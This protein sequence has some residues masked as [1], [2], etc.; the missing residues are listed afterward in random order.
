MSDSIQ[1]ERRQYPRVKVSVPVEVLVEAS[2]SPMRCS[3]SDLSL[4]GCYIETIF[5]LPIGT[6]LDLQ[7]S[8]DTT[9]LIAATVV[10]CDPQVGNG[11]K[12]TKMLPEDREALKAYLEAAQQDQGLGTKGASAG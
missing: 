7:L 8:L 11:M 12:F 6:A 3:T 4:G 9:I 1:N 2:G 10:T 5:P